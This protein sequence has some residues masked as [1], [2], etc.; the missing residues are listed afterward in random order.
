MSSSAIVIELSL[1]S[2]RMETFSLI[3]SRYQ[4]DSCDC[5]CHDLQCFTH[6]TLLLTSGQT[7]I[8]AS[9]VCLWQSQTGGHVTRRPAADWSSRASLQRSFI[10]SQRVKRAVI[11]QTHSAKPLSSRDQCRDRTSKRLWSVLINKYKWRSQISPEEKDW[12]QNHYLI[13]H[14]AEHRVIMD[15][16]ETNNN[17]KIIKQHFFFPASCQHFSFSIS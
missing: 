3:K 5:K 12:L 15:K 1:R 9:R 11:S 6:Q 17:K 10:R 8:C 16:T 7:D 2:E 13:L 14:T 4:S